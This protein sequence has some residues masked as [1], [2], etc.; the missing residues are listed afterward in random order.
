MYICGRPAG[1]VDHSAEADSNPG[2]RPLRMNNRFPRGTER[3]SWSTP[4]CWCRSDWSCSSRLPSVRRSGP[5]HSR[6][7]R[8]KQSELG[9]WASASPRCTPCG[10]TTG[11]ASD[12]PRPA[13]SLWACL[14]FVA[15]ARFPGDVAWDSPQAWIYVLFLLSALVAGAYGLWMASGNAARHAAADSR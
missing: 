2:H 3:C 1:D 5:G 13:T 6:R 12:R 15:L 11:N 9:R 7:S 4:H 10:R 8:H 14:E